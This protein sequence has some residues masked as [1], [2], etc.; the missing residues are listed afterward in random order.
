M[1]TLAQLRTRAKRLADM[2]NS[3]FVADAEW[4]DYINEGLSELH[5]ILVMASDE[6]FLSST[7]INIVS[8][9]SAYALPSDFYKVRGV[10]LQR[11]TSSIH[12]PRKKPPAVCYRHGSD[13]G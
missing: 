3:G 11:V 9:T 4:L 8:G 10:D 7:T 2:E 13:G 6:Y 12:V 1:A 5:D